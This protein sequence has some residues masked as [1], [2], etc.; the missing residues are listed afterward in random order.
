MSL[1]LQLPPTSFTPSTQTARAPCS[2]SNNQADYAQGLC[3]CYLF[4][5]ELSSPR[6]PHGRVSHSLEPFFSVGPSLTIL[7]KVCPPHIPHPSSPPYF[8]PKQFDH[9][10]THYI[11]HIFIHLLSV[12]PAKMGAPQ[13]QGFLNALIIAMRS[14]PRTVPGTWQV[15][16]KMC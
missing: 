7:F 6:N 1:G 9:I 4:G 10:L 15:C 13:G 16:K 8:P 12:S 3:I 2:S 5:S 11:I 14:T